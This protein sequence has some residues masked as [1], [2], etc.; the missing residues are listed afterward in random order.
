VKSVLLIAAALL[1]PAAHAEVADSSANGF[2]VKL[3]VTVQ[4]SPVNAYRKFVDD[5]GEWWSPDH[6]FSKDAHNL[7]IEEKPGGCFCEQLADGGGVR[8]LEI[9][10]FMPGKYVV[11]SGGLGPLQSLAAAGT[12]SIQFAPVKE[13]TRVDVIYTL[14]GYLPAGM[15]TWAAPVDGMLTQTFGRFKNYIEHGEPGPKK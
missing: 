4:G 2:T 9:V 6:T 7:S 15:N 11:M 12:L 13:G 8:H 14:A 1:I 3:T 10:N 5:V